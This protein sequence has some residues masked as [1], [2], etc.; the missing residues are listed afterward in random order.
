MVPIEMTSRQ[1]RAQIHFQFFECASS[2]LLAVLGLI[3]TKAHSQ[4]AQNIFIETI[5]VDF[6][7]SSVGSFWLLGFLFPKN[8]SVFRI[9]MRPLGPGTSKKIGGGGCQY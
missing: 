1:Q 4:K 8:L 9:D 5:S 6:P 7:R 3:M 2:L